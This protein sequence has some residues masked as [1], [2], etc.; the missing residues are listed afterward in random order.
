MHTPE[1]NAKR[2]RSHLLRRELNPELWQTDKAKAA[3]KANGE[4][5]KTYIDKA[6][7]AAHKNGSRSAFERSFEKPLYDLGFLPTQRV[8]RWWVDYLNH[9][10]KVVVECYGDWHHCHSKFDERIQRLYKGIH[11]ELGLM[12]VE[13]RARDEER[14]HDIESKGYMTVVI[15]QHD[16][17]R[18][19]SWIE[20][21]FQAN[22]SVG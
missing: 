1:A 4:K 7:A 10:T 17:K 19:L 16:S 8:G 2:S 22:N 20:S 21:S 14:L 3:W 11:P 13:K 18:W 9:E 5:G 12:P 15:W 6:T